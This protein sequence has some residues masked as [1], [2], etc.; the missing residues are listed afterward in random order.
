MTSFDLKSLFWTTARTLSKDV[1]VLFV[2]G[3]LQECS[4]LQNVNPK[5]LICLG[6]K[7]PVKGIQNK[8][9]GSIRAR[10]KD[11]VIDFDGV[12]PLEEA[13]RILKKKG[14]YLCKSRRKFV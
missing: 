6:K 11:V 7:S 5:E 12:L 9:I 4:A 10:S 2:S 14:V 13:H 1:R 3:N 8:E